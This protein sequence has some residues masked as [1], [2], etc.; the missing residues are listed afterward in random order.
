MVLELIESVFSE[1]SEKHDLSVLFAAVALL[2]RYV[3]HCGRGLTT[4][5]LQS[6]VIVAFAVAEKY[7]IELD[8]IYPFSICEAFGDGRTYADTEVEFLRTLD[9]RVPASN[10]HIMCEWLWTWLSVRGLATVLVRNYMC[11]LTMMMLPSTE[12]VMCT[13]ASLAT[14]VVLLAVHA[15][16]W[17]PYDDVASQLLA[18]TG[19]SVHASVCAMWSVIVSLKLHVASDLWAV[20]DKTLL[21]LAGLPHT[22]RHVLV[23]PDTISY[24]RSAMNVYS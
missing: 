11:G 17:L 20:P 23:S 16:G 14:G 19:V 21:R 1:C 5:S 10:V 24:V 2:D 22:R 12:M 13:T 8:T 9:F 4:R 18:V 15:C 6:R 3:T 7:E